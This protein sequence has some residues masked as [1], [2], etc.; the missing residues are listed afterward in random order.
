MSSGED[1][2]PLGRLEAAHYRLT[3]AVA[4]RERALA[5]HDAATVE[6]RSVDTAA[7]RATRAEYETLRSATATVSARLDDTIDR[8]KGVLER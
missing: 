2:T 8:L 3:E 4:R 6:V 5:R 1:P 7:L